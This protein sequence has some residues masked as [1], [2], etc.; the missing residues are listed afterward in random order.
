MEI[1]YCIYKNVLVT[2]GCGFIGS[3]FLNYMVR[4][5]PE[6]NFYNV[7]CLMYCSNLNNIS[8]DVQSSLNYKFFNM[9]LQEKEALLYLL[10]TYQIDC[11]VHFAAQSHVDN[12]FID[13]LV[14]T[15]DNVVATH[16][17]LECCKQAQE[18][19]WINLQ[20]FIHIST[21][22][23]YGDSSLNTPECKTELSNLNPTNPYAASKA[24][25]EMIC[26]SYYYSYN[27]PLIITRSNNV[28]GP[29]QYPDKVIPKFITSLIKNEKCTIHGNGDQLRS[30]IHVYDKVTAIDILLQRGAIGEIYNISSTDEFSVNGIADLLITFIKTE[31]ISNWKVN[32][33]DRVFNDTRYLISSKKL[34]SLGW[35]KSISFIDGIRDLINSYF[36][37]NVS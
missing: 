21:D 32:I 15:D 20:K 18:N 11:V 37:P 24:A 23:V 10:K 3:N 22:E 31:N 26:R 34:E 12:S 35:Y 13:S 14:F 17:L 29:N 2:G 16:I 6:V 27:L 28:Y 36:E 1:D 9:K 25:A 8:L 19:N 4:K 33:T 5:Y 7:D 30:F